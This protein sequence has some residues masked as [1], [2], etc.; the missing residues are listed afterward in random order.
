M[1]YLLD[2]CVIS[3]LIARKPD[4]K[5]VEWVD[6]LDVESIYL[7][8]ITIGEI[9]KG[10]AKLADPRRKET[11]RAWLE[12][13]LLARF[14]ERIVPLD[15]AVMLVWGELVGDLERK[16]QPMPAMDSL[17]A[18]ISLHGQYHLVTRNESDFQNTG[19]PVINPWR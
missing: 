11:L 7:S 15:T 13:E 4:A 14:A 9:S 3:E 17:I 19:V 5:V 6:G 8:V 16:G 18:A 12:E 2:T 10:I 1:K